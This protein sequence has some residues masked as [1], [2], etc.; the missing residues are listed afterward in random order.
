MGRRKESGISTMNILYVGDSW[1]IRGFTE[2]NSDKI[3]VQL[4]QLYDWLTDVK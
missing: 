3:G 4:S 1:A 2:E